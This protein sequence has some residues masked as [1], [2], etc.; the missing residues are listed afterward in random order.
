[1]PSNFDP[2]TLASIDTKD[3]MQRLRTACSHLALRS[4][5]LCEYFRG[6]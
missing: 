4:T 2:L 1:M 6:H 5:R 3:Q